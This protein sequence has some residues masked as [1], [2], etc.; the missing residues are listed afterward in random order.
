M[1]AYITFWIRA[2]SGGPYICLDSWGRS[3]QM[4]QLMGEFVQTETFKELAV[5]DIHSAIEH[6]RIDIEGYDFSIKREEEAI[7][8]LRSCSLNGE[9]VLNSFFDSKNAI[10]DLEQEKEKLKDAIARLLFYESIIEEQEYE[11][12][13]TKGTV[14]IAL[15]C[16]PNYSENE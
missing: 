11:D 14:Y 4:F 10:E 15:E 3:S 6:A 12:E 1:S 16:N 7:E 2:N 13:K 5:A 9:E 8:F